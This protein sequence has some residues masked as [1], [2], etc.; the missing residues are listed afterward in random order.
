M[1]ELDLDLTEGQEEI[2]REKSRNKGLSE[3]VIQTA[4]ERD[5]A[6]ALATKEAAEKATALKDVEFYKNFSTVASKYQGANEYQ[7]QIREKVAL[8]LDVED[9]TMLVLTKEGKYTP[10][11]VAVEAPRR[12]SPA[13]GSAVNAIKSGGEKSASEMTQAERRTQLMEA[14]RRG[15]LGLS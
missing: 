6:T 3:K 7:D 14:E 8:G 13:G 1:D 10:A 12:E 2:N 4:K 5:E 9:A 11:P 15:D